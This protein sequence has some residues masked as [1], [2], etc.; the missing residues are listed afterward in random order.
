MTL[1]MVALASIAACLPSPVLAGP[2]PI[3]GEEPEMFEDAYTFVCPDGGFESGCTRE[4]VELAVMLDEAP[5]SVMATKCLYRTKADCTVTASGQIAALTLGTT[6]HWQLAALQPADG[7]ATEMMVLFEQ[8]GAV[9]NLLLSH[10]TEGYFDPPVTVR[11]ADGRFMLHVPARN[12]GLGNADLVLMESGNGWNWWT[13]D[14]LIGDA[15]RM[16]PAGFTIASPVDFNLRESSAFALV[17]RESDPGCCASGGFATID[18]DV[19]QPNS[20]GI[21]GVSFQETTPGEMHRSSG[22]HDD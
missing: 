11:D 8:D 1:R 5:Q 3:D 4:D 10:Q 6:L 20:I 21:A 13:A 12:R 14:Q 18:F 7:P 16:L 15:D 22:E 9:P 2:H 19:S 17:R